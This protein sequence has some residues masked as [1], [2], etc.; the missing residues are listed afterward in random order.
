MNI[1]VVGAGNMGLVVAAYL[2]KKGKDY[3]TIYTSKKISSAIELIDEENGTIDIV[4]NF[5][6]TSS[7][8][9]AFKK[10][11]IVLCTYPAF[12][13]NKFINENKKDLLNVH[14]I[15]F[16]PGYGGAEYFCKELMNAGVKIVGLQR[17]PYV[18]R[19]G[20]K[21]GKLIA[22][23]IS[24]KSRLFVATIPKVENETSRII[25]EEIF[26]IETKALKEYLAVTLAPSNPLLHLV[27]VYNLY[28]NYKSGMHYDRVLGFYEE[29]NDDASDMLLK[30]DDEL[31][32][33]CK[34]MKCFELDEVVP[35]SVYYESDTKEKMT[36]K[37]KSIEAFKCVKA[38]MKHENDGFVPDFSSRMF[39]EDFPYGI[40]IFK[41]F[42]IMNDVKTPIMD[43]LLKF[44][45]EMTGKLYF[46]KND[47]LTEMAKNTGIPYVYGIKNMN[48]LIELYK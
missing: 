7:S 2:A 14:S 34:K 4:D 35:L 33:I 12:L 24:K 19:S 40:C 20:Y 42:A 3:V 11:S 22:H 27:G 39:T 43:K 32:E 28:H 25:V 36:R 37:L 16:I 8:Q 46:D 38:P 5:K 13:R 47:K 10:N 23:M 1:T 30:Y 29:W 9:E 18:A 26:D 41:A 21:E 17:V 15:V 48:Q 31:Q 45:Y 44:Y 6:V